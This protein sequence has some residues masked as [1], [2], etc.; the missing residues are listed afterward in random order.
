[1]ARISTKENKNIYQLTREGLK[2]TREAA[3]GLLESIPPERIEKIENKQEPYL[4]ERADMALAYSFIRR[5]KYDRYF[6]PI[7]STHRCSKQSSLL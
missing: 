1:M 7:S 4:P 5:H 6:L 2:L 3:S